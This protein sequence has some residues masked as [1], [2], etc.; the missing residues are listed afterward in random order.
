MD[1][2]IQFRRL[3]TSGLCLPPY[4]GGVLILLSKS[5]LT[6]ASLAPVGYKPPDLAVVAK[7]NLY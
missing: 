2:T 3:R 4:Y 5:N 1:T 6:L 7:S